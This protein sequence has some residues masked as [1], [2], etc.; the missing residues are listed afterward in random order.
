M[1][2]VAF[3]GVTASAWAV[4]YVVR[5]GEVL[6]EIIYRD[7]PGRIYGKNGNLAKILQLNPEI[8]DPNKIV[9]GQKINFGNLL[10]TLGVV[11]DTG[12]ETTRTLA[13][14]PVNPEATEAK[15]AI[16]QEATLPIQT[17]DEELK[18]S[19]DVGYG[20]TLMNLNQ[21]GAFGGIEGLSQAINTVQVE[22][23]THYKKWH[24]VFEFSNYS[25]D[26]GTDTS[27]AASKESKNF[28]DFSVL[29][30]YGIFDFGIHGKTAPILK[31]SGATTL[32]WVDF[33]TVSAVAGMHFDKE[34]VGPSRRPFRFLSAFRLEYPW[35]AGGSSGMRASSVSGFAV[36]VRGG[37]EK[38]L[39]RSQDIR[40]FMGLEGG[41]S[42][43]Q[44]RF[45]GSFDGASGDIT[46]TLQE[47]EALITL[48]MEL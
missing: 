31:T 21:T 42:Y 28:R 18:L 26:F 40:L 17:T 6:S 7:I 34:F 29:G 30:G 3:A 25:L 33:T 15:L 48:R 16:P 2:I 12:A 23:E 20:T 35:Q 38:Q 11:P 39:N 43:E 10:A 36:K 44:L 5:K 45:N 22:A 32:N 13:S 27:N 9:D 24:A 4:T 14:D 46:R 19:F 37:A 47:Y 8:K 41:A 1:S